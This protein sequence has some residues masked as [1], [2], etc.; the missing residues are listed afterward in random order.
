[1]M[2]S[3]LAAIP[4]HGYLIL[5][6]AVFVET[7]GLPLPAALAFLIA[8][9]ASGRGDLNPFLAVGGALA[10]M[11]FGDTLMFLLGRHTGWWL[12]GILCRLSL[13][14]ESC[15]LR[16]ADSF[17][18]RG[19]TLLVFAKFLPG[20]NSLAAPLAGSMNMRFV[21]FFSLDCA[22]ATLYI[23]SYFA[24]GYV[25]T[26][27]LESI[28]KGYLTFG[29]V[30]NQVLI[31]AA[32]VYVCVQ[33]YFWFRA[34]SLPTVPVAGPEEVAQ[35]MLRSP[36]TVVFDV[37][38]HGYYDPRGVRIRG[39][40]RLDPNAINQF[41]ESIPES[42]P[43]YVYCTCLR[44]ATSARVARVLMDKHVHSAVIL[45]GLKAW[46]KAGLPTEPIPPAEMD[47]LPVFKS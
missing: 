33:A 29:H 46:Q 22:G 15:I 35:A 21:Q 25:F 14:P 38:S 45:G 43:V 42:T 34:R 28:T 3:W 37:R 36:D 39:S 18:R 41:A 24:L 8:G 31:A 12:L 11:M 27:A 2:D 13:N 9:G 4:R 30:L 26:D 20:I 10:A 1:M 23:V 17:Y 6:G 40:R 44:Q 5:M 16:S 47:L 32:G 19:R 7:V